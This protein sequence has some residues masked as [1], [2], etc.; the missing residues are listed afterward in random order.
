MH[1]E[2]GVGPTRL[3]LTAFLPKRIKKDGK[4]LIM[5]NMN[6][7]YRSVVGCVAGRLDERM[8]CVGGGAL[9]MRNE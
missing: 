7:V 5:K 4:R 2:T 8:S 9:Q 6:A 3:P 1:C